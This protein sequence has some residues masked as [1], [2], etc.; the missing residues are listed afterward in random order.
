M[1]TP[2][3]VQ[4]QVVDVRTVAAAIPPDL[5][6]D[7]N[8]L[9][10]HFY[11]NFSLL[12]YAGGR[13]PLYYQLTTYAAYWRRAKKAGTCFHATATNIGEFAKLAGYAELETMW[14]TDSSLPQPDPANPVTEFDPR[15]CKFA[16]Y[17]YA[18]HLNKVRTSVQAM[19]ALVRLEVN[20]LAVF[21]TAEDEQ[22]EATNEWL[23]AHG[24]FP[25]AVLVATARPQGLLD[26]LSDDMDL[27]TF[28]GVT[29]YTANQKTVDAARIA[30]K[31]S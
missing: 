25:D 18:G 10:W 4:A 17:H 11:T 30:G 23:T 13:M 27:A 16:R 15:V 1:I 14:R 5:I 24:D 8:V 9:Y 19:I 6:L 12:Q 26:I 3:L 21:P 31:L 2:S 22:T 29:L 28:A 7:A 20:L